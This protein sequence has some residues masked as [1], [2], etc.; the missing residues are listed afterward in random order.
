MVQL[1]FGKRIMQDWEAVLK[2]L[3]MCLMA[4]GSFFDHSLE[5]SSEK[6][7]CESFSHLLNTFC[8]R[9]TFLPEREGGDSSGQRSTRNRQQVFFW[10]GWFNLCILSMNIMC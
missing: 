8:L 10:D 4:R 7:H 5:E 2:E 9:H 6:G 3:V 1:E